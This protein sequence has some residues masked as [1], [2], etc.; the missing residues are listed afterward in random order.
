MLAHNSGF[1]IFFFFPNLRDLSKQSFLIREK[2][3]KRTHVFI[4]SLCFAHVTVILARS[5][6]PH[7]TK[8]R[9]LY[10]TSLTLENLS[11]RQYHNLYEN[12][13]MET[14]VKQNTH[15]SV[16]FLT[17]FCAWDMDNTLDKNHLTQTDKLLL[18]YWKSALFKSFQCVAQETEMWFLLERYFMLF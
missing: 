14:L 3:E 7:D 4:S 15:M 16:W 12:T 8:Q 2:P 11:M 9:M 6:L 1:V 18:G 10:N 13:F 5:F 17:L